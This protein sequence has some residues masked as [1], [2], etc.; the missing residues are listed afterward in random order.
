MALAGTETTR[1]L[2]PAVADDAVTGA[3]LR[4]PPQ[5]LDVYMDQPARTA[6][7]VRLDG[8]GGSSRERLPSPIRFSHSETVESASPRISAIWVAVIRSLRRA[9]I[10]TTLAA[11]GRIGGRCGRDERSTKPPG[12]SSRHRLSQR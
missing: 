2:A 12:P 7:L 1:D 6:T 5:L 10:A 8:S 4:N 11:G 9:W 3:A